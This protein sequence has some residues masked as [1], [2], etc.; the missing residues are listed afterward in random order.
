MILAGWRTT[1]SS[2]KADCGLVVLMLW[3][4]GIHGYAPG[5]FRRLG[6]ADVTI[7]DWS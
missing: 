3:A 7:G 2:Y 4:S 1:S 6:D 5:T